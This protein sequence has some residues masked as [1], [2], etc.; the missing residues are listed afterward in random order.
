MSFSVNKRDGGRILFTLHPGP[1]LLLPW[2]GRVSERRARPTRICAGRRPDRHGPAVETAVTVPGEP[3]LQRP[4]L[5]SAGPTE[6]FYR[7]IVVYVFRWPT[8]KCWPR[9]KG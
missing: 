8:R 6:P 3:S 1:E 2:K 5:A 7:W 9:V 4:S